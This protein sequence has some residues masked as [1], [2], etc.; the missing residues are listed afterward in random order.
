MPN[1][2]Y[3][4]DIQGFK[5]EFSREKIMFIYFT[6]VFNLTQEKY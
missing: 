5:G 1:Q 6:T 2:Y 4:N 3:I